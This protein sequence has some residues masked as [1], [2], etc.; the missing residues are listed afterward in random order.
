MTDKENTSIFYINKENSTASLLTFV[1]QKKNN[2][3]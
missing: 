2:L 3:L 1:H